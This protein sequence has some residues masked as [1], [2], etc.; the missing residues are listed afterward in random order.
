MQKLEYVREN[1]ILLS[2]NNLLIVWNFKIEIDLRLQWKTTMLVWKTCKEQKIV[3][4]YERAK[5]VL[6]HE[7]DSNA[8]YRWSPRNK[9]IRK[10]SGETCNT[11][12]NWN[13]S[14]LEESSRD[15]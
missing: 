7:S 5:N 11:K 13:C 15:E 10:E 3:I 12:E 9:S 14:K 8:N 2:I 4:V 6:E 1:E